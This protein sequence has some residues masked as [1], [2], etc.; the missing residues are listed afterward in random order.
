MYVCPSMRIGAHV[1][2]NFDTGANH[3]HEALL[4][5][6]LLCQRSLRPQLER[7][8]APPEVRANALF[9]THTAFDADMIAFIDSFVS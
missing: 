1:N 4:P 7:S 6:L 3:W 8:R 5:E 2:V 9:I